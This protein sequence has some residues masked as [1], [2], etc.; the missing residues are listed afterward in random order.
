MIIF[1]SLDDGDVAANNYFVF[2]NYIIHTMSVYKRVSEFLI[3]SHANIRTS[4]ECNQFSR[5]RP[6]GGGV[7]IIIYYSM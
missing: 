1:F 2:V 5:R 7:G 4:N 3:N 6:G